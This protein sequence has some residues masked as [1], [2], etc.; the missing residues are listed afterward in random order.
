MDMNDAET[1]ALIG[2][3]HGIGKMHGACTLG[4]GRCT[5]R[6]PVPGKGPNTFTSGFEGAWGFAPNMW[7]NEF[8]MHLRSH[9]WEVSRLRARTVMVAGEESHARRERCIPLSAGPGSDRCAA[10]WLP[11]L[12]V[13]LGPGGHYQWRPTPETASNLRVD[14]APFGI[15][16]HFMLTSDIA[17]LYDMTYNPWVQLY[18]GNLTELKTAFSAAW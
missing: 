7:T 18:A 6:G 1:V 15:T 9:L 16:E 4:P 10:L 8:F 17:L 12:Q 14:N 11:G 5:N 13:V 3:G 2:G